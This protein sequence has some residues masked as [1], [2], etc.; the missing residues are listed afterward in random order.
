MLLHPDSLSELQVLIYDLKV[1]GYLDMAQPMLSMPPT[2]VSPILLMFPLAG[3][4]EWE[5]AGEGDG[6]K[7][8]TTP[9]LHASSID[10]A[11]DGIRQNF[12]KV[13]NGT[14]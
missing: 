12:G 8:L 9:L 11:W 1:G 6:G 7:S 14:L 13:L 3:V 4:E 5:E 10:E 2:E